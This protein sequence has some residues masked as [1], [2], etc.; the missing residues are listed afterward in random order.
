MMFTKYSE[1]FLIFPGGFGTMDELF[2]ALVLIQTGKIQH[3]PVVLFGTQYWGGLLDWMKQTMM[4]EGKIE[5]PDLALLYP[6]DDPEEAAR[7]VVDC[8][9]E[10]CSAS[11][12]A[13]RNGHT[14]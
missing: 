2:E 1:A 4:A 8:Y 10:N 12:L 14:A 11:P 7:I 13:P 5:Q 6:T 9:N 3:F